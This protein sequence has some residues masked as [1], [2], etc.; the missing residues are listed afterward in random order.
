MKRAILLGVFCFGLIG[1][2]MMTS[3]PGIARVPAA[4]GERAVD[5]KKKPIS[6]LSWLVGGVWTADASKM[7]DGMKRIETRY[8][9]SDNNA[10]IRFTTH[11]V[12]DKGTAKTYDGN[13]FWEPEKSQLAMWYMDYANEII[14]GPIVI[15]GETTKFSFRATDF[16]GKPAD[17]E[18]ELLRKASDKYQWTLEEKSGDS[19]K[20]LATL[21]YVRT[22]E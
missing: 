13:F 20:Q 5:A 18:V 7:G 1:I 2:V 21:E 17:M 12:S 3:E 22:A 6:D 16:E 15:S 4:H 10:F 11:F 9:W 8:V 14:Q 19:W